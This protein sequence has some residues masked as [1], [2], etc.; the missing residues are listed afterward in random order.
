[1]SEQNVQ[2]VRSIL[3]PL[4]GVNVAAIDWTLEELRGVAGQA[5]SSE[6]ELRTL[7]SGTGTGL[8]EVYVGWDGM[9]E[10]L[11]GWLEPFG[12]YYVENLD[13]IDDGD[14]VLV[15]SRQ[16]GVGTASGVEV[17]IELTTAY[18]LRAGKVV[19]VCQYDTVEQARAAART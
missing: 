12:E 15:P 4:E 8:S 7:E 5:Y 9:V 10:Y 14:R 11:H 18:E 1:M 17:E 13:Y 3:D 16:R 2:L 19:R 6:F